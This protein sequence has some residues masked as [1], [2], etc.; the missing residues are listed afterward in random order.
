M[1]SIVATLPIL[2]TVHPQFWSLCH[3]QP[4]SDEMS[5]AAFGIHRLTTQE[6]KTVSRRGED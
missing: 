6:E 5:M 3:R 4:I 2:H 1:T